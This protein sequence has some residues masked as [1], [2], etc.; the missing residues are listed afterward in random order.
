MK[1]VL[2]E[3]TN[4]REQTR[5]DI[6]SEETAFKEAEK[7]RGEG[8]D[9]FEHAHQETQEAIDAL[10]Q[11]IA[12]LA[13]FY[14]SRNAGAA[15]I[16]AK[17]HA[18]QPSVNDGGGV[19]EMISHTRGEFETAKTNLETEESNAE[20][21]FEGVRAAYIEVDTNLHTDENMETVEIQT[22]DRTIDTTEDD[23]QQENVDKVSAQ[24]YLDQL[25]RSCYMLLNNYED[26]KKKRSE[27]ETAIND[28]I[29][30]LREHA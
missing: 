6:V 10:N 2:V 8:K 7:L 14:A 22:D 23:L 5:E 30:V 29:T 12:I 4:A 13:K 28:A 11:A 27:E 24:S 26:R 16:Q 17:G 15:F 18:M 1:E 3:D 25:G 9:E 21:E 19:V 20:H